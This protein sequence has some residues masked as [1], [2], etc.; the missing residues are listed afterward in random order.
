MIVL[1]SLYDTQSFLCTVGQTYFAYANVAFFPNAAWGMTRASLDLLYIISQDCVSTIGQAQNTCMYHLH[2]G[3]VG[4][5][6]INGA[7]LSPTSISS[8]VFKMQ[9][10]A[11]NIS[12]AVS[13]ILERFPT[14]GVVTMYK[15]CKQLYP[16]WII[17]MKVA[18][19]GTKDGNVFK[20]IVSGS[21]RSYT[22]TDTGLNSVTLV[23]VSS[24]YRLISNR[25][26]T[27]NP[28]DFF[29]ARRT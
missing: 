4:P 22:L 28:F 12:D 21:G 27:T 6:C 9:P 17:S 3:L 10:S 2:S 25:H 14:M 19:F 13:L 15:H 8:I 20:M 29:S 26:L 5:P 1:L 16:D 24:S 18:L 11:G 23:T 7:Q